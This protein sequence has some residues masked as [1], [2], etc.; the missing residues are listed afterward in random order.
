MKSPD[1]KDI[2]AKFV[3]F[4]QH[5]RKYIVIIFI[6]AVSGLYAFLII[7]TNQLAQSEPDDTAVTEKLQA[8]ARP[9]IDEETAQ[10][11]EQ[12]EDQ[13]IQ[14]QSLFNEARSNPFSE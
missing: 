13:N 5:L 4:L 11:L 8:T 12:L 14:I 1:L 6:V 10:K 9:K 3:P 7:R 2:P